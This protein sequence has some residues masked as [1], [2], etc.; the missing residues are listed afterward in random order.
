MDNL[1]IETPAAGLYEQSKLMGFGKYCYLPIGDVFLLYPSYVGWVLKERTSKKL[2]TDNMKNRSEPLNEEDAKQLR[3]AEL[4]LVK[5]SNVEEE[6]TRRYR[7]GLI[8]P[9][10]IGKFSCF[11]KKKK[12]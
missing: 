7:T 5:T 3:D 1:Q 2:F 4:F 10:E 9:E 6:F 11:Q 12:L 8:G